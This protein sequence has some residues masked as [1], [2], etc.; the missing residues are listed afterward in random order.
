MDTGT[1]SNTTAKRGSLGDTAVRDIS[2]AL[3]GL[4]ADA[5][6]LYMKTKPFIGI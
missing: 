2:E 4:L 1:V 3:R 6:C 5:F